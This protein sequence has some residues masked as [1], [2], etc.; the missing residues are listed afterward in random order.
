MINTN[1][2]GLAGIILAVAVLLTFDSTVYAATVELNYGQQANQHLSADLL[3]LTINR[4][5]GVGQYVNSAMFVPQNY[6]PLA[7]NYKYI[8][9]DAPLPAGKF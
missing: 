7:A 8:K 1:Q 5:T 6:E 9:N 2:S 3:S 4:M